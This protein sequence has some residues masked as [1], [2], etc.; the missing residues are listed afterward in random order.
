MNVK[1]LC[2]GTLCL[3]DSTGYE[4][5]K[6]FEASFS[7][8]HNA[9]YGSIYPALNQLLQEDLV[10]CRIEPGEKHPNRKLFS[11]ND[12]GRK[13]FVAELASTPPKEHIRSEFLAQTWTAI[14]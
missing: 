12:Q 14:I 9:S 11:I 7:H 8:F 5:K 6:L 10:S 4:I 13:A 2:L 3:G 1:T